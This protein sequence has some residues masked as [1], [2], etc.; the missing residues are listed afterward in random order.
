MTGLRRRVERRRRHLQ[1]ALGVVWLVDAGLQYQPLMFTRRFVTAVLE[2]AVIGAPGWVSSPALAVDRLLAVH[3]GAYNALFATLELLIA[4][5]IFWPPLVRVGLAVSAVWALS[6]W[7][8][9]EGLG[10]L[11]FGAPE[12]MGAPGAAVLYAFAA[13]LLW[14][15]QRPDPDAPSVGQSG[16][17]GATWPRLA[18]AALW[19]GLADLG[20]S[21]GNASPSAL[22]AM[23]RGMVANEPSWV[24]AIDTGLAGVVGGD[25]TVW[26]LLLAAGCVL[27]GLGV[28][29]PR[30]ARPAVVTAAVLGS[31][32]WLMED[33]GGVLSGYATDVSTGPV[34]VLLAAAFWPLR[35]PALVTEGPATPATARDHPEGASGRGRGA[36]LDHVE[37]T[38]GVAGPQGLLVELADRRLRDGLDEGPPLG[39]PPAGHPVGQVGRELLGPHGRALGPHHHRQ[40]PLPPPLVGDADHAGLHH[41]GVAHQGGLELDRGDPLAA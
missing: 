28:F 35:A 8:L 5:A 13:A 29:F 1:V 3:I 6:V 37:V 41:V 38:E 19:L 18:W 27:A 30:L 10:G 25:G 23:L 24:R 22:G 9:G 12:T 7:W 32:I 4:L 36:D 26:S 21:S 39:Q 40:R 11:P 2:Q 14:P 17:L 20:L 31:I 16:P 33:F 34:L 15:P